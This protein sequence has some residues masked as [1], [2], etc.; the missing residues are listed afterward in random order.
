MFAISQHY[1]YSIGIPIHVL[2]NIKA[3]INRSFK[4]I[5]VRRIQAVVTDQLPIE[6]KIKQTQSGD[7]SGG[8]CNGF[9][10][11]EYSNQSNLLV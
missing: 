6:V 5:G 2:A 11:L 10:F 1:S 4:I 3:N 8:L 7:E 9:I